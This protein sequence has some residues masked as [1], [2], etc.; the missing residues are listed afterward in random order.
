MNFSLAVGAIEESVTVV[1]EA[2]L[3]SSTSAALGG[4][5][6]QKQLAELPLNGRNFVDLAL[7]QPG[8]SQNRLNASSSYGVWF[9]VNGAPMRSNNFTLDGAPMNSLVGGAATSA[10]GTTLGLDGIAEYK[11]VTNSFSAE[12]GQTMGSQVVIVSKSGTNEWHGSAFESIRNSAL[13]SS[14]AFDAGAKPLLERNNFGGAFGGPLKQNKMFFWGVYEGLRQRLGFTPRNT[15]PP[16]A[17]HTA[18]GIVDGSCV[19]GLAP[20]QTLTVA[21]V[22]RPLLALLPPPNLPNNQHTFDTGSDARVDYGQFRYDLTLSGR[23]SLFARYT[24]DDGDVDNA[25]TSIIA[26]ASGTA[27][28]GVRFEGRT[29]N[30]FLTLS[31]NHQFSSTVNNIRASWSSVVVQSGI[32]YGANLNG[33]EYSMVPGLPLGSYSVTGFSTFGGSSTS[34]PPDLRHNR[35]IFSFGDDLTVM[36]GVHTLKFGT[37]INLHRER[38]TQPFNTAGAVTFATLRDFVIGNPRTLT[39]ATPGAN[40]NH[41]YSYSTFGFYAHD[42]LRATSK[43]TVNM[44]LRYEFMTLPKDS[45]GN[46]YGFRDIRTDAVAQRGIVK[47]YTLKNFAPRVGLAYDLTGSGKT[48]LRGAFGIFHDVGNIG[49]VFIQNAYGTPPTSGTTVVNN[50]GTTL[51]LPLTFPERTAVRVLTTEY[52]AEQPQTWQYNVAIGQELPGDVGLTVAYVG[53]RGFN[54]WNT[55]EGNPVPPTSIVD[56]ELFWGPS[57]VACAQVVPTCRTNPNW[58]SVFFVSP[59]GHIWYDSLQINATKRLNRGLQAQAAF[60]WS[61]AIDTVQANGGNGDGGGSRMNPF[62]EEYDKGPAFTDVPRSLRVSML[63]QFPRRAAPGVLSGMLNGWRMAHI[64]SMQ[65]GVPFTPTVA[66]NRSR[67]GNLGSQTDRLNLGTATVGRGE[68]GPDGFVNN[69]SATFIPY[70]PKKVITGDPNQWFNPYMFTMSP[71]GYQGNAGRNI[72]RCPGLFTWDMSLAREIALPRDAGKIEVRIE[73]FNLSNRTNY[74]MP[75]A[76]AFV[77]SLNEPSPYAEVSGKTASNPQGNAGLI[78]TTA[79]PARQIQLSAKVSF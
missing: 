65:D 10:A 36:K 51:T 67:S 45:T 7:L 25:N 32:R 47:N 20:G 58:G 63:Y 56:G 79:T 72:L 18:N 60:T 49:Q 41:D 11:V 48:V 52:N 46:D 64:F 5:I 28:P 17:C 43:L 1:G 50:P 8:V 9:T 69:T 24:L 31:E 4:L 76:V 57:V 15:V 77:G 19:P 23:D 74:G 22:I 26:A 38:I 75:N 35:R 73:I 39:I 14:N 40:P 34:G 44:G 61:K 12:Y 59:V 6:D 30:Q 33:P 55:L 29:R 53:L 16:A 37:L 62:N 21:P 54:I 78:T 71:L 68:T 3:I 42:D 66:T 2:P 70:D 27:M 13:D